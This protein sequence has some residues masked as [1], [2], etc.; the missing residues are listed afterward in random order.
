MKLDP[1]G[2]QL[3]V[4]ASPPAGPQALDTFGGP[5]SVEWDASSPLTPLGQLVYFA[6]FLKVSG[7]FD[8]AVGDCPLSYSSPNA[9]A[10]RDVVGTPSV[11]FGALAALA[12]HKR[13]AHVTAL[14]S[15]QVLPDLLG[16][17]PI[18]SEDSLRRALRAIPEQAGLDWLQGHL[19][20]TV[21]PL[22]SEPY[23]VD[24]DTTV[25]PLYG[26][27]EGALAC[28]LRGKPRRQCRL[29]SQE[30]G[31]PKPCAPHLY[32]GGPAAGDGRGDRAQ[33]P[34]HWRALRTRTMEIDRQHTP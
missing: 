3:A 12:G 24:I 27:Q 26:H 7:R 5:V 15:D 31:A 32:A 11:G 18:V 14:R 13:H 4:E 25:K 33:Q 22:L 10:V 6:E 2:T 8:A 16:K 21:R 17:R 28:C 20:A 9:P 34:A 23:I 1:A 29:Q 30:A 19:D